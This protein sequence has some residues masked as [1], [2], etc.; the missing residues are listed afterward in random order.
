MLV[1]PSGQVI[2]QPVTGVTRE[3]VLSTVAQFQST[4]TNPRRPSAYRQ[5][6][7]QLY[8]W[9]IQPL[10]VAL[11][12]AKI[13]TLVFIVDGG[14]RSVPLAALYDGS[15]FL[16]EQYHMGIMPSLALSDTRYQDMTQQRVLAMGA[17]KFTQQNPL[18][19]VPLELSVI[20]DRLWQGDSFLNETFTVK[21]L[22]EAHQSGE[23]GIIHLATHANFE[24]GTLGNSYIQFWQDQLTLDQLKEFNFGDP[25][26]ELLVLSACRTAL[27]DREAELGFAGAAVLAQ[28][29]TVLGSL[30]EVSDEGTLG[31]MT[32][33]Y[34]QLNRVPLKAKAIREAQ[35]SLLRG[36]VYIEKGQL[37]TPDN[38]LLLPQPLSTLEEQSLEHPYFWSGFT[39]IG[40]PW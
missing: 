22:Q 16:I 14:L 17:S 30:W 18:P 31:L 34:E 21:Q 35:L 28:V 38:R 6:A 39:L 15:E 25:P 24:T 2:R 26:I 29:K 27:G 23:F 4:I 1:T 13:D 10:K 9:F 12:A 11:N 20:A 7:Q 33:F 36:E 3:Q 40:S 5:P 32:R 8:Q 19:A 37:V